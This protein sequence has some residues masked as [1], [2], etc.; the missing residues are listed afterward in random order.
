MLNLSFLIFKEKIKFEIDVIGQNAVKILKKFVG[1][2]IQYLANLTAEERSFVRQYSWI[3]FAS[4]IS[5][6][7]STD[8]KF[9]RFILNFYNKL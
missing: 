2:S 9:D 1:M 3:S 7:L 8:G 6:V 5:Q 4:K